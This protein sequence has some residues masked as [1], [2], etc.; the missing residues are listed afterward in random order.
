MK[1]G[2]P[3]VQLPMKDNHEP[4]RSPSSS[5]L[6]HIVKMA[7][8]LSVFLLVVW[9]IRQL[10]TVT[11]LYSWEEASSSYVGSDLDRLFSRTNS[12][13][14]GQHQPIRPFNQ[15]QPHQCELDHNFSIAALLENISKSSEFCHPT[16]RHSFWRRD[17]IV[18]DK[19]CLISVICLFLVCFFYSF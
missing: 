9:K 5:S 11:S 19:G 8:A 4:L 17:H 7:V 6:R 2:L 16:V 1:N 3:P 12:T 10:H 14:S 13:V 18:C 15:R